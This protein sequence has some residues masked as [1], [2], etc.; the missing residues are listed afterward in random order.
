MIRDKGVAR[1][2]RIAIACQGGGSHTAFA[3][4]VLQT[5][6]RHADD[7]AFTIRALSGTAA[8]AVC[9][10]LAWY[11]LCKQRDGEETTA[12]SIERIRAFWMDITPTSTYERI[13]NNWVVHT[14]RL[15][16]RGVLPVASTGPYS[17]ERAQMLE[18]LKTLAPRQ[19][20]V[21]LEAL[22]C[23]HI[24][25]QFIAQPVMEPR[26]LIGGVDV[27]TGEFI[28]FD[29]KE[30]G[31]TGISLAVIRTS[32]ALP[33]LF[34]TVDIGA[35]ACWDDA[36]SHHLPV[37]AFVQG[38]AMTQKPDEIW[39]IRSNP[40]EYMDMRTSFDTDA[41]CHNDLA[42]NLSLWQEIDVIE[43]ANTWLETESL[44]RTVK[45]PITIHSIEM[46]ADLQKHLDYATRLDR[47]QG[48]ITMLMAHGT[49][50]GER[51]LR[52]RERE[53]TVGHIS[54]AVDEQR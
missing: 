1:T 19:E 41:D 37:C 16:E 32:V 31:P 14:T 25:P 15:Q 5:I 40:A 49:E 52:R 34:P 4:G 27:L 54:F 21:D 6:L 45:K 44:P 38:R 50:Q 35:E 23:K 8:G 30:A 36:Y 7:G 17:A 2:P 24:D 18:I 11:G 26:L 51:F 9:A 47:S 46:E 29:S 42:D 10:L 3:A 33:I 12:Q 22:L 39:I 43:T 28:V 53:R 20:F 13:W 48:L